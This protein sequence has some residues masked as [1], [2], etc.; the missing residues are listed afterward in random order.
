MSNEDYVRVEM[1]GPTLLQQ[2]APSS[3]SHTQ[4][5]SNKESKEIINLG[6]NIQLTYTPP[7]LPTINPLIFNLI[8]LC[9]GIIIGGVFNFIIKK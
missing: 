1:E 3:T 2:C 8:F 9:L 6:E 5:I 7:V 4:T